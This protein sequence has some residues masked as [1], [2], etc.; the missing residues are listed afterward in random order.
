MQ[1]KTII[2]FV[3]GKNA[4]GTVW[5]DDFIRW[6]C[7]RLGR[8]ELEYEREMPTGWIYW[9]PP[10]GGNDGAIGERRMRTR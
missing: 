3:G 4:T 7:R 5:A 8:A 2:R 1:W 9:L 10:N 6:M